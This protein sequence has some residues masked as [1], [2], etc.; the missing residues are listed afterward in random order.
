MTAEVA[1][2]AR[3]AYNERASALPTALDEVS[4]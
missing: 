4:G 3:L 1:P 2:G